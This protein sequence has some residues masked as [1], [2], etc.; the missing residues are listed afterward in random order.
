MLKISHG[1]DVRF[2][3]VGFVGAGMVSSSFTWGG[4]ATAGKSSHLSTEAQREYPEYSRLIRT[5]RWQGRKTTGV[6]MAGVRFG[7]YKKTFTSDKETPRR[8]DYRKPPQGCTW[9]GCSTKAVSEHKEKVYCASHLL[10]SLQQQ[11]QV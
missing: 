5:G 10:A 4:S 6:L 7:S 11:W 9:S 3:R 8:I 1:S 2:L